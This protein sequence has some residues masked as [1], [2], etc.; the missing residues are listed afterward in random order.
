MKLNQKWG[1]ANVLLLHIQNILTHICIIF[2]NIYNNTMYVY[3]YM[4]MIVTKCWRRFYFISALLHSGEP[5]L[6]AIQKTKKKTMHTHTNTY[7]W[8]EWMRASV[9]RWIIRAKFSAGNCSGNASTD[10]S[11]MPGKG[12]YHCQRWI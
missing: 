9:L 7:A 5:W 3:V 8:E 12:R 6:P 10:C 1:K 11:C 2:T 4:C